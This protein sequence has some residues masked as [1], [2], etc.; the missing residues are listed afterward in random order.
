MQA[1]TFN[2][3]ENKP[4]ADCPSMEIVNI[5]QSF[6]EN[7]PRQASPNNAAGNKQRNNFMGSLEQA[8]QGREEI[9]PIELGKPQKRSVL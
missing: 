7:K 8:D 3:N 1:T 5:K 2:S 9:M 4:L 6:D